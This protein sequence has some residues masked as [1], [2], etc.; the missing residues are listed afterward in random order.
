MAKTAITTNFVGN[1]VLAMAG[2]P[3]AAATSN[4]I[5]QNAAAYEQYADYIQHIIAGGNLDTILGGKRFT[6]LSGPIDVFDRTDYTFLESLGSEITVP[7]KDLEFLSPVDDIDPLQ[8]KAIGALATVPG[9]GTKF[10]FA[11]GITITTGTRTFAGGA[12]ATHGIFA[13]SSLISTS[14]PMWKWIRHGMVIREL[15]GYKQEQILIVDIGGTLFGV[16][17]AQI[18]GFIEKAA[19]AT[20]IPVWATEEHDIGATWIPVQQHMN[21]Y[22]EGSKMIE[23]GYTHRWNIMG[24]S[25]FSTNETWLRKLLTGVR[26]PLIGDPIER[27]RSRQQNRMMEVWNGTALFGVKGRYNIGGLTYPR[28]GGLIADIKRCSTDRYGSSGTDTAVDNAYGGYYPEGVDTTDID[29]IV[30]YKCNGGTNYYCGTE[31]DPST[32]AT[33]SQ[34][35]FNIADATMMSNLRT[36][37]NIA[38]MLPTTCYLPPN[39]YVIATQ[40]DKGR[41]QNNTWKNTESG[42][43]SIRYLAPTGNEYHFI[44]DH[45]L[46]NMILLGNPN[47]GKRRRLVSAMKMDL[48]THNNV[49]QSMYVT[50]QG[51]E[52]KRPEFLWFLWEN[53]QPPVA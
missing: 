26:N 1:G 30:R 20:Q 34:E 48:V 4:A 23:E 35:T 2:G 42:Y 52:F 39:L 7:T 10:T 37:G 8:W 16:R 38:N 27:A 41:V 3:S 13:L 46:Q 31:G 9:D 17:G 45:N 19:A 36:S 15:N 47:N 22:D 14:D 50:I 21:E 5:I 6:D 28:A 53:L 29:N 44:R 51:F 11:Y 40:F 12:S 25:E 33:F 18:G 32:P 24:M 43:T 49:E